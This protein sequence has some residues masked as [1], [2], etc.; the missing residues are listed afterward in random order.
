MNKHVVT[1]SRQWK[2]SE[3]KVELKV[4]ND[5]ISITIPLSEFVVALVEE[6]KSPLLMMTKTHL[7]KRLFLSTQTIIEKM[8]DESAKVM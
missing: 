5:G 2:D 4:D 3:I 1:V 7:K 6:A 8:K